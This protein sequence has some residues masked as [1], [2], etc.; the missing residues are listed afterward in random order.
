MTR[1]RGV[2]VPRHAHARPS[3]Q[4]SNGPLTSP[5]RS[6]RAVARAAE[7]V[8]NRAQAG[9]RGKCELVGLRMMLGTET[10]DFHRTAP[11]TGA[12]RRADAG[13]VRLG[14]RDID[15]LI[16]CA[17]HFGAPDRKST[18]LN[19]SHRCISY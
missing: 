7:S 3:D 10:E 4:S 2:A 19:S 17:E 1:S 8:T 12:P 18:R 5:A 9:T 14:Q 6:C 13:V 15:G 11:V 16:L